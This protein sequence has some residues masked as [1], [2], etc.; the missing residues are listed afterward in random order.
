MHQAKRQR[1]TNELTSVGNNN[2]DT[3]TE[4]LS[5]QIIYGRLSQYFISNNSILFSVPSEEELPIAI[6]IYSDSGYLA[7]TLL[8]TKKYQGVYVFAYDE[9]NRKTL[10]QNFKQWNIT[11]ETQVIPSFDAFLKVEDYGEIIKSSVV[12][13][14]IAYDLDKYNSLNELLQFFKNA[15]KIV[16]RSSYKVLNIEDMGFVYEEI[17]DNL[18]K[19]QIYVLNLFNW[20]PEQQEEWSKKLK[21]FLKKI[22]KEYI[23]LSDETIKKF[24]KKEY[25]PIWISA[26]VTK[27]V[28]SGS[29]QNLELNEFRGDRFLDLT[30][31]QLILKRFE[32]IS[33]GQANQ[34]K[35]VLVSKNTLSK[36][37]KKLELKDLIVAYRKTKS[38]KEDVFES[39]IGALAVIAGQI[40]P[41]SEYE[42]CFKFIEK[43]YETVDFGTLEKLPPLAPIT[44]I[45]QSFNRLNIKVNVS[46]KSNK[47]IDPESN[48]IIKR[49]FDQNNFL[50]TVSQVMIKK[51][52]VEF[53]KLW[54]IHIPGPYVSI[55]LP[56]GQKEQYKLIGIGSDID[57]DESQKIAFYEAYLT[58]NKSGFTPEFVEEKAQE[59]TL[60]EVANVYPNISKAYEKAQQQGFNRLSLQVSNL[61]NKSNN[62]FITL[63]GVYPDKTEK[64]L[65]FGTGQTKIDAS[66]N[67]LEKYINM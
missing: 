58:L 27:A 57:R 5:P 15:M 49:D 63:S 55:D 66:I 61:Q 1:I 9:K 62:R 4:F 48:I 52:G 60:T 65:S 12:F 17:T 35:S 26:F 22:L 39:F 13:I 32:G 47:E 46:S 19:M 67:A 34:L 51:S 42:Y 33:Q 64:V 50:V 8:E 18:T 7:K 10:E 45:S 53:L 21:E 2:E 14:D 28:A 6:L 25:M 23:D 3:N 20:T 44:W 36:L 56:N 29:S 38:V 59:K 54:N 43:V 37:T 40:K 30:I 31:T 41:F 11:D 16:I 24:I